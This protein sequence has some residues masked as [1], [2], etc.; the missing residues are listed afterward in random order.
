MCECVGLWVCAWV[1]WCVHGFVGVLVQE[2][3][4]HMGAE[5]LKHRGLPLLNAKGHLER[6]VMYPSGCFPMF[7]TI[8][9]VHVCVHVPVYVFV[10]MCVFACMLLTWCMYVCRCASILNVRRSSKTAPISFATSGATGPTSSAAITSTTPTS[11]CPDATWTACWRA[12][13]Q[14]KC[15]V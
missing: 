5:R 12:K 3:A 7:H 10:C 13:S 2:L 11:N 15:R 1:C 9:F 8:P 6:N 14:V 4:V